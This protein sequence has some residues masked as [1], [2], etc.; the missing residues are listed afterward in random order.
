MNNAFFVVISIEDV[1]SEHVKE[2]ISTSCFKDFKQALTFWEQNIKMLSLE[3]GIPIESFSRTIDWSRES[4][5][6]SCTFK[7]G[8]FYK[9]IVKKESIYD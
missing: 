6:Y 1:Y 7:G 2:S 3:S 9:I 5:D 4:A 8:D